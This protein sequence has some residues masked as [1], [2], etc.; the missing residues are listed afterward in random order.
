MAFQQNEVTQNASLHIHNHLIYRQMTFLG[1]ISAENRICMQNIAFLFMLTLLMFVRFENGGRL[2]WVFMIGIA[3]WVAECIANTE[4]ND[5][6]KTVM[7]IVMT[8]LYLRIVFAWGNMLTPYKTFLTDG[9][10]AYDIIW[11]KNEYD[12]RYDNDK[13]YKW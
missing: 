3:C 1:Q 10:R 2:T 7:Y 4:R 12:H 11:Q 6:S 5:I 9:V 13:L 8:L